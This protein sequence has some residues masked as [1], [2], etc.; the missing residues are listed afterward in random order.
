MGGGGRG[1]T[2]CREANEGSENEQANACPEKQRGAH[3]KKEKEMKGENNTRKTTRRKDKKATRGNARKSPISQK[4]RN[5]PA[6]VS[7][8]NIN[9]MDPGLRLSGKNAS[10]LTFI[11][12]SLRLQATGHHAI[13]PR[14][15]RSR[16][17][18]GL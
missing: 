2:L 3:N 13:K 1:A 14:I 17:T 9:A 4:V 16:N 15:K 18:S 8:V 6:P 7:S 5:T 11:R 12:M 10:V